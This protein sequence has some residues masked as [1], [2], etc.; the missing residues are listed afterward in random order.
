MF[1][2]IEV[3]AQETARTGL[4]STSGCCGS[5][6]AAA[7]AWMFYRHNAHLLQLLPSSSS[8]PVR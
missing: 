8:S 6:L 3:R 5:A 7:V 4:A 1:R 2:P